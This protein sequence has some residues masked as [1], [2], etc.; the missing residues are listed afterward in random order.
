MNLTPHFTLEEMTLSQTAVRA[1]IA[2]TPNEPQILSLVRLCENILEPLRTMLGKPINVSSGFRN[3]IVNSLVGGSTT[4]QHMRG[5][6]ADF[7]VEGMTAQELFEFIMAND[8]PYDQLI[9]E[10]DRWIHISFGPR[11]RRQNLY[12]RNNPI[13]NRTIYVPA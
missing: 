4:S 8:L 10:F 1:G 12:A 5:E 9:Q 6:A 13:N 3:P 11:K 7:N 2:N